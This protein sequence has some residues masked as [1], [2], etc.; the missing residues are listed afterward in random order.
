MEF[1]VKSTDAPHDTDTAAALQM[2]I[3]YAQ[4]SICSS[5]P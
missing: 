1:D 2:H 3:F 4:S 5:V